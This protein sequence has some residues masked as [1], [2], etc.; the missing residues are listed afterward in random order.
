M[1][2]CMYVCMYVYVCIHMNVHLLLMIIIILAL[3]CNNDNNSSHL[4]DACSAKQTMTARPLA[5]THDSS[6]CRAIDMATS[7]SISIVLV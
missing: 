1:Y 7:Y 5:C 3:I 4:R 2:V 6:W